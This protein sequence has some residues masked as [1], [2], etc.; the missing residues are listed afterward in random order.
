MAIAWVPRIIWRLASVLV[1]LGCLPTEAA[2]LQPAGGRFDV[3]R[4]GAAG[5]GK[6][7]DTNAIQA[8]VDACAKAGGGT[9]LLAGGTFLSGTIDL[10][11]HVALCVEPGAVLL[12]STNQEDFTSRSLIHAENAQNIA[13]FGRGVIDGH[14]DVSTEFPKVRSHPIHFIECKNIQVKDVTFRNSTTWIQHYFKCD[15]LVVDGVTVDSRINPVI[16]GPRHLPGAP[17]RNE[18]GLNLNSCRKVRVS[19]CNIFSDDDGI[20]LKSTSERPCQ[21]VTITNCVVSSNASA[22]KFG[23][24]S[25]GGFQNVTVSNCTIHDTRNAGIALEI[26]DGGT[27]DRVTISNIVMDNVKGA[28]IFLRLGNRGRPYRGENPGMGSMRNIIISNVQA[29]RIGDW[30]EPP[31]KRT[32]GCSITG[33]PGFPVENVTLQ[34]IRIQ[35]KGGGTLEDAARE[36]PE[37]P[38]AYPSCR[39]FGTL[40]A[41]GFFVRHAKNIVFRNID[42]SF[43][44]D[45]HRPAMIFDD[46]HRLELSGFDAQSIPS[47]AQGLIWM[48]QTDGAWIHGCRLTRKTRTFLRV[49]GEKSTDIC[50]MNNDLGSAGTIV[51][52][53][54]D[55]AADAV[56]LVNSR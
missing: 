35:F 41:Y 38:D 36:I 12:A 28:A 40:P 5:D 18:D 23:T 46:V 10:R 31:G 1:V 30:I 50:L 8:A 20:V 32:V 44:H 15:D 17:G 2:D 53:G 16:E 7:L 3:R 4:Y 43:E 33:L 42:L 51:E 11:D 37:R 25:G 27:M 49:D 6:T 54:S 55:V 13:V 56:R 19:N 9:V 22:I 26:V 48:R 47:T 14:G 34:N 52:A 29:T 21:D 45:D 24:E 39:M